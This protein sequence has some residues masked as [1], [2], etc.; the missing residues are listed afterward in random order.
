VSGLGIRGAQTRCLVA[1]RKNSSWLI[2][3]VKD[4][5]SIHSGAE[6]SAMSGM[7]VVN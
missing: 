2:G 6:V 7:G 3:L 5:Y 4:F 1:G